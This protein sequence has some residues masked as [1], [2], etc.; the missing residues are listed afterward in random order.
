PAEAGGLEGGGE[1]REAREV[2]RL[3]L[4]A[5]ALRA[6]GG[7]RGLGMSGHGART[8]G[9]AEA[10]DHRHGHADASSSRAVVNSTGDLA[11]PLRAVAPPR[12]RGARGSMAVPTVRTWGRLFHCRAHAGRR[13]SAATCTKVQNASGCLPHARN[14]AAIASMSARVA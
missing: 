1:Q 3:G 11:D 6:P 5:R 14:A 13:A 9:H 7:G 8:G 2:I 4:A 10:E 12:A